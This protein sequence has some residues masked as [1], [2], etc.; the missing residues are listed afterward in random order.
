MTPPDIIYSSNSSLS[1][2]DPDEDCN[3]SPLGSEIS[4]EN[5]EDIILDRGS[6]SRSQQDNT[7]QDILQS[8]NQ[9]TDRSRTEYENTHLQSTTARIETRDMKYKDSDL[10][11]RNKQPNYTSFE[12]HI[13]QL[14]FPIP[15]ETNPLHHHT[16]RREHNRSM[17]YTIIPSEQ[18][19]EQNVHFRMP[20]SNTHIHSMKN[21]NDSMSPQDSVYGYKYGNTNPF[22]Y[23]PPIH[24]PNNTT[25][26][27][28]EYPTD[29]ENTY[30][31]SKVFVPGKI[32]STHFYKE[33]PKSMQH[34]RITPSVT[35]SRGNPLMDQ[36][37][38]NSGNIP[39]RRM[40]PDKH[41]KQGSSSSRKCSIL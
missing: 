26:S 5:E 39:V 33:L 3:G 7:I 30:L 38:P 17:Y 27:Q 22:Q 32:I 41:D 40:P 6:P 28:V 23:T 11:S 21:T 20:A 29:Y 10:L 2:S 15:R 24:Y 13:Q 14:R 16:E 19:S 9:C 35:L 31:Q 8:S 1:T 4:S 36:I 25:H 18:Y 12:R 37:Q 34:D